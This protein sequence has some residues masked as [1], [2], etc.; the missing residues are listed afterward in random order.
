MKNSLKKL[1]VLVIAALAACL[2]G[3]LGDKA[4]RSATFSFSELNDLVYE[5][6]I[7]EESFSH[8][9]GHNIA[10]GDYLYAAGKLVIFRDY[11]VNLLPGDYRYAVCSEAGKTPLTVRVEDEK[12]K[13]RIPNGGFE[14]GDLFGWQAVTI[15][16]GEKQILSFVPAGIRENTEFSPLAIPYN[17]DGA[18]LY[19]HDDSPGA[20]AKW[21][22]RMGILRSRVFE[23]GGSGYVTFKLGGAGNSDLCYVSVRAADSDEEIARFGNHQF[24]QANYPQDSD[25]YYGANLVSYKADLSKH[26][27]EKLYI[28]IVDMGGYEWDFITFDSFETY[29]PAPPEEGV[30]AQDIKPAF[31]QAFIPNQLPNG[32]FKLGL[33]F[34]QTSSPGWGDNAYVV[35]GGVLK[36][37]VG[38][39]AARGLIRSSLFRIEGSGVISLELAAAQGAR[40]DKDTFVSIKEE[41]TNR[42]I[43][44][45]ANTRSNGIF[46]VKYY[47]DLSAH[48]GKNCYFEIVDNATG[49]YDT[50]FV[51]NIVTYYP[52]APRFDYGQSGINLNY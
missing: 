30:L 45:L 33:D 28:E 41:K 38:G 39:D 1:I 27:G 14:T 48:L 16:K 42:E 40:F 2:S 9:E 25:A 47:I 22:E 44:R 20:A 26:L 52:V 43:F 15:F 10:D 24:N 17:G 11:L 46:P 36:S 5:L 51:A 23:L 6:D 32:D 12:Q 4:A 3:C 35:E 34:W 18:Y 37:N 49:V 31:H 7:P 8:L 50:I 13:Y 19:G 29:H 21:N